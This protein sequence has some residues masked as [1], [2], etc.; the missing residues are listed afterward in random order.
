MITHRHIKNGQVTLWETGENFQRKVTMASVDA[1][2]A[3]QADPDRWSLP[4]HENPDVPPARKLSEGES[5]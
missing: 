5:E 1:A 4:D 2:H 3:L